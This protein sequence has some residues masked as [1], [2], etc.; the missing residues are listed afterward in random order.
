[1][2]R[3]GVFGVAFAA[4]APTPPLPRDAAA[5]KE[6]IAARNSGAV[7]DI[8]ALRRS[9]DVDVKPRV[10][11]GVPC[12]DITPRV[13]TPRNRRRLIISLHGGAYIFRAGEAGLRDG[14][15]VAGLTGLPVLSVDYRMPPDHPYPAALDDALAVWREVGGRGTGLFGVSAGG[16]L[17]LCLAQAAKARG[18]PAPGAIIAATPW[19]DLS[20]TG[21]SYVVNAEADT[22]AVRYEGLL[23]EAAKLYAAGRDLKDPLV[24]PVYGDFSGFAPT[25]LTAGTRDLFLSNAV[26]VHEKLRAAGAVTQLEVQEGHSHGQFMTVPES[27]GTRALFATFAT[28][29][30][31]HLAP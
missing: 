30:D 18:L 6:Y 1:M 22:I 26:R 23:E 29:L 7:A 21:D 2:E 12:Y 20:K 10:V 11:A 13:V 16:G 15:I 14:L 24:S 25:L 5:W 28:F 19:S 3:R 8:A 4:M 27:A 9:F 17:A 31:Q